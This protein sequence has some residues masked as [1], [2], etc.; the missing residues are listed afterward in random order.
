MTRH[1][2][3]GR[4][5][6]GRMWGF[7]LVSNA[8]DQRPLLPRLWAH[9][10]KPPAAFVE[11]NQGQPLQARSK[12]PVSSP[13]SRSCLP[14][15]SA[16]GYR[17]RRSTPTSVATLARQ[18]SPPP[19]R[20]SLTTVERC[21][22]QS[23]LP[24]VPRMSGSD[25]ARIEGVLRI[26][27]S[28]GAPTGLPPNSSLILHPSLTATGSVV[29]AADLCLAHVSQSPLEELVASRRVVQVADMEG[30]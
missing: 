27:P 26:Y 21:G 23:P 2:A 4:A 7:V 8:S 10:D 13:T 20:L 25:A 1:R 11:M 22:R 14:V 15:E 19:W 24:S 18:L 28:R 6:P 16:P 29:A 3:H 30:V 9:A 12:A 17:G 5:P